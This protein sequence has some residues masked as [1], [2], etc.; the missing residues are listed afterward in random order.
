MTDEKVSLWFLQYVH[1]FFHNA[2]LDLDLGG[3]L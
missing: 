1:L 3:V 2:P